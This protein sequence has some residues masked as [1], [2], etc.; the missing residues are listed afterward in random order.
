MQKRIFYS[1]I[2]LITLA[3][4]VIYLNKYSTQKQTLISINGQTMGTTYH[5]KLL[6]ESSTT[7]DKISLKKLIDQR[8]S[9]IDHRMS[10]YKQ[11]SELSLFNRFPDKQ[12]MPISSE[13]LYVVK[14]GQELSRRTNGAFDMTVGKLVN[15]WGFGPSTKEKIIPNQLQINNLLQYCGYEKIQLKTQPPAIIKE[16]NNI[17]LDL[18]AIAKGYAVDAVAKVILNNDINNFLV[19]VG[20]EIITKGHKIN[21]MPWVVGIET[22][23]SNKRK[24]RKKLHLNGAAMATSGD[25][26]N[27]FDYGGKRYSHTIDP[28]TGYPVKHTLASVTVVS[29]SCMKADG[30]ATAFMVMG[31]EK[32][33]NFSEK[34]NIAIFMIIKNGDKFIEK[35]SAAFNKYLQ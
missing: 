13:L 30:L 2:V 32:G 7:I 3:G 14:T 9:E 4:M 17:F 6:Q 22:P 31:P 11:D 29:G 27:F 23:V 18:S 24:I 8:L 25:Y 35:Q 12:W 16:S 20:G 5:I 34:N 28:R 19:E 10:T 15:L 26:R 33:L 21:N 1:L